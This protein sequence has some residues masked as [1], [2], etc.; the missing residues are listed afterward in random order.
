MNKPTLTFVAMAILAALAGTALLGQSDSAQ[1]AQTTIAVGNFWF[2]DASHS[3]NVCETTITEGDTV[4]WNF[5][6]AMA[7]HTATGTIWDSGNMNGG[8]FSF[9][10]NDAGSYDYHCNIHPSL[11]MGRII[12]QAAAPEPTATSPSSGGETPSG[13]QP[14]A[15]RPTSGGVPTVVL[16]TTG[17]GPSGGASGSWWLLGV[18]A[19]AGVALSGLGA[20]AYTR[21]RS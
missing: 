10:F 11:M 15:T 12:V 4:V 17:Q 16:P 19:A 1:A 18:I 21:R 5:A 13:A 7:T 6:G 14:T 20:F 3:S 2:C 8:T 9:T